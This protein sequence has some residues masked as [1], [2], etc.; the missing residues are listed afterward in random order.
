VNALA[1]TTGND[2]IFDYGKYDPYTDVGKKLLAHELTHVVQQQNRYMPTGY[3]EAFVQRRVDF[4]PIFIATQLRTAMEGLGTDE[5]AI[6]SALSGRTQAQLDQISIAY[7][8][9]TKK[10]LSADLEDELSSDDLK[11]LG[12]F[13]PSS[14]KKP[15]DLA[16]MVAIQLQKAMKGLGTDEVS[17]FSALNGRSQ[18]ELDEIKKAYLRLTKRD[19]VHDLS[20]ELSGDDLDRALS[21]LNMAPEVYEHNTELGGLSVG[22]FDFHFKNCQILN[23][24]WVKFQFTD[25]INPTEQTAFKQR[26][27]NAIHNVWEFKNTNKALKGSGNCPCDHVPIDVHVQESKSG[28]YHKLVDVERKSDSDRRPMVISDINV[29]FNTPDETLAHEFGHVLGLYDEYVGPWYENMMFWHKNQPGDVKALMY[30]GGP[31]N[32]EMRNRYFE[33]YRGRVQRTAPED[34]HYSL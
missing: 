31:G 28:Y 29:N 23:W 30:T 16:D 24:V 19:L 4:S 27:V 25:D 9:L 10:S 3:G 20:D 34:C 33:H 7:Q 8:N 6:F 15:E 1:Y 17:I 11:R 12:L 5:E 13:S 32:M 26:F 21:L 22:N 14:E 2:I 18:A